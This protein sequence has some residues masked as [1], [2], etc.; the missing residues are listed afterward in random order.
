[1]DLFGPLP[2][3]ISGVKYI[4][5]AIDHLPKWV[6]ARA[7][8]DHLAN[9]IAKFILEQIIFHGNLQFLLTDN[10]KNLTSQV[11]PY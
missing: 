8:Q 5:V 7:I 2:T 6:K 4:V 3:G 1:M 10:A 9:T 11:L